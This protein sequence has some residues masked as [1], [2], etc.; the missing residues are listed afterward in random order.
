MHGASGYLYYV[1][2]LKAVLRSW[3]CCCSISTYSIDSQSTD[4]VG[5]RPWPLL[6]SPSPAVFSVHQ[7]E[8][9]F[10]YRW[11]NQQ[12][13]PLLSNTPT[14]V[15]ALLTENRAPPTPSHCPLPLGPVRITTPLPCVNSW[16]RWRV[17]KDADLLSDYTVLSITPSVVGSGDGMSHDGHVTEGEES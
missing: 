14:P 6:P 4:Q 2:R 16:R 9:A 17:Q 1:W 7:L 11:H 8:V 3:M 10:K 15:W 13:H 5:D 12:P